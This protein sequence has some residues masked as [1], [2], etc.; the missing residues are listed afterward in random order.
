MITSLLERLTSIE[1]RGMQVVR[2]FD[3]SSIDR[4][5]NAM[6]IRV[7]SVQKN[8]T[9]GAEKAR[10]QSGE[11]RSQRLSRTVGLPQELRRL[12][13][14]QQRSRFFDDGQDFL[15]EANITYR[16]SRNTLAGSGKRDEM[17]VRARQRDV[18]HFGEIVIGSG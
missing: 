2:A 12:G 17:A 13:I 14:S 15:G 18:I 1:Q 7:G 3:G 11:R 9:P 5:R 16:R 10:K 8:H 6:Q 4:L